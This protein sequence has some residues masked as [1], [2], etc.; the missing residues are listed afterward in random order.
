M[1]RPVAEDTRSRILDAA[2]QCFIH[3]G[4]AATSM[5]KIAQTSNTTNSLIVHHFGTKAELWE[6]VKHR[7][8]QGFLEKQQAIL[9]S[10]ELNIQQFLDATRLYFEL[11]RDDPALVQLLARAELEQDLACSRFK[12]ELVTGFVQRIMAGQ[13]Q[14]IFHHRVKPAYLLALILSSITQ[15]MEARHQFTSWDEIQGDAD[16]DSA[17]LETLEDVLLHGVQGAKQ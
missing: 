7:R 8:M 10:S 4:F 9:A 13:Q 1:P 17:F 15:W 3:A 14:Q 11:L 6:Q 12:Q 16:P 5:R 2:E